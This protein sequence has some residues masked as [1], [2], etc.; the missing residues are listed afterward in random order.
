MTTV[1][2]GGN[3]S[4]SWRRED[5]NLYDEQGRFLVSAFAQDGSEGMVPESANAHYASI[6]EAAPEMLEALRDLV[7]FAEAYDG[8]PE[9]FKKAN[10]LDRYVANLASA[11]IAKATE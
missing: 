6:L 7:D 10:P 4:G 9:N 2:Q 3:S 5:G 1:K 8:Q 11:A